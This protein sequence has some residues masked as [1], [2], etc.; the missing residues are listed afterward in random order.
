MIRDGQYR[1]AGESGS[2]NCV[3][4]AAMPGG[5]I[6]VRDSKDREGPV[7]AF[8]DESWSAFISEVRAGTFGLPG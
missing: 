6:R 7:L 4:V 1:K 5:G 3:E 2:I 8:A